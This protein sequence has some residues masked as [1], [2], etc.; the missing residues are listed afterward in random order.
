VNE[1]VDQLVSTVAEEA[2]MFERLLALL[3]Q[4]HRHLVSGDVADLKRAAG[5]Q[6]GVLLAARLLERRR[7]DLLERLAAS[8]PESGS[9]D[10]TRLVAAL[11]H[12]YARR[13]AEL[14]RT[15]EGSIAQLQSTR[16]HNAR[17]IARSLSSV[18]RQIG[19]RSTTLTDSEQL[20]SLARARGPQ[21]VASA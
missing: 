1:L 4:Q 13:F 8:P 10:C 5:D 7:H 19:L 21:G 16:E 2:E 18:S 9:A 20:P 11:S 6:E 3:R 17:L 12:D 14:R 15:L